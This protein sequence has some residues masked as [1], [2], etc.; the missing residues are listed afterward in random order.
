VKFDR[1]HILKLAVVALTPFRPK[2]VSPFRW[3]Q[4]NARL[5][6]CFIGKRAVGFV[7]LN[8]TISYEAQLTTRLSPVQHFVWP[9]EARQWIE[10]EVWR[11]ERQ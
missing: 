1:R 2:W 5:S 6:V 8:D 10:D 11:Q 9:R 7:F 3:E 4:R